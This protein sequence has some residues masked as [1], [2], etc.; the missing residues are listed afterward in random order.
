MLKQIKILLFIIVHTTL[1]AQNYE[2]KVQIKG[3]EN[4]EVKLVYYL[5]NKQYIKQKGVFDKKGRFVFSGKDSLA[6]GIYKIVIGT[7]NYFDFLV[8]NEQK[9]S[10]L[11]DT[12]D[13]IGHM[14]VKDSK[15]NEL[16]FDYQK[17]V[18]LLK[19]RL[20]VLAKKLNTIENDTVK[21]NKLKKEIA[22]T[23]E[24]L[25]ALWENTVNNFP[26]SYLSK[27][28]KAFNSMNVS[29]FNFADPEMLHT[30]IY[31]TMLRLFIK[32]NINKKPE[33]IIYETKK[34]LDSLKNIPENYQYV[35][36][37]LL[38]FYNTFYKNGMNEVFVYI[39]DHYFLPDKANWFK[40]EQ[41]AEI[42]KRRNLLGQ[43]LPGHKAPDLV[44]ESINGEYL[45]LNQ[46][47]AKFVL[48]YFWSA[49]CGHC[50]KSST[51][52]KQYYPKLQEKNIEIFAVN[53]DKD[54]TEWKKKVEKMNL[55]WINCQ[56][57]NEVSNYREKY[58]V[59]GTPLLYLINNKQEILS[60]QNGEVEIEKLVKSLVE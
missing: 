12:T 21:S 8:R 29:E 18:I 50:T 9:F 60:V 31:H 46:T 25:D 45:S 56:D 19:T 17:K 38:N 35:A 57:I 10:L 43:S 3:A 59:Y 48:L 24:E 53:T 34:L 13:F 26:N 30:P 23:E 40:K 42:Q 47:D 22:K 33:Y 15:E 4:K 32:Q 41:L 5:G 16:F 52:L 2:I 1:F 6:T 39:A 37:Y 20:S 28:L 11:S 54:S 7:N 49:N 44:L 51:I 36:N 27:I 14:K 55:Q 58:Y